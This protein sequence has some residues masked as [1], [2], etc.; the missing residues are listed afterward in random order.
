MIMLYEVRIRTDFISSV[1]AV[2]LFLT[3]STATGSTLTRRAAFL[4]AGLRAAD[5]LEAGFFAADF[6]M[7]VRGLLA[8]VAIRG[9]LI[10]SLC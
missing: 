4:G 5:L 10:S 2:R 6:F 3:S 9:M 8:G 1:A 7:A